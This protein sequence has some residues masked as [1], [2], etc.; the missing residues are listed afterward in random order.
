MKESIPEVYE[1][2]HKFSFVYA[3]LRA[4]VRGVSYTGL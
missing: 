2:N 4:Y 1:K 3:E